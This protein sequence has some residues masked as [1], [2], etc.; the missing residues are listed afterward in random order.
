VYNISADNEIA[1]L[2]IAKMILDLTGKPYSLINHVP[3]RPGNDRRYSISA[4]KLMQELGWK[5]SHTFEEAMPKTVEWYQHNID[6]V[7][8]IKERDQDFGNFI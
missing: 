3:D 4:N 6:W 7:E 8:N 5:P 2:D 1:T